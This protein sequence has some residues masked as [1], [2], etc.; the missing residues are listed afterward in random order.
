MF[1]APCI[2]YS[3]CVSYNRSTESDSE[4]DGRGGGGAS[5]GTAA[6]LEAAQDGVERSRFSP[7]RVKEFKQLAA[8]PLVYEKVRG[9]CV[10]VFVFVFTR[11]GRIRIQLSPSAR[12]RPTCPVFIVMEYV[13]CAGGRTKTGR[14]TWGR[15]VRA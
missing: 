14:S 11:N 13:L 1:F 2:D 4:V 9:L 12:V 6:E 10:V 3:C 5:H 7:G 15:T 8:D